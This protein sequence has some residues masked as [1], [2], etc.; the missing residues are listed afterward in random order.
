LHRQHRLLLPQEATRSKKRRNAGYVSWNPPRRSGVRLTGAGISFA[1]SASW[2]GP[3]PSHVALSASSASDR[4]VGLWC[5]TY[6]PP[7]ASWR[8]PSVIRS[9]ICSRHKLLISSSGSMQC[10][11]GFAP[12]MAFSDFRSSYLCR[13]RYIYI[14]I[15][16]RNLGWYFVLPKLL[17]YSWSLSSVS[18]F[19][20]CIGLYFF[21]WIHV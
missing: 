8:S 7:S 6:S 12:D 1:L 9:A 11:F 16:I 15:H 4:Y 21:Y 18:R 17:Q 19:Y 20:T 5:L 13:C 14:Y 2:S 3:K 10:M